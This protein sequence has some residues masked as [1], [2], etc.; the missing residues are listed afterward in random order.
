MRS[1]QTQARKITLA[2]VLLSG[3]TLQPVMTGQSY[4]IETPPDGACPRLE[5]RFVVNAQGT[6][7]AAVT[8]ASWQPVAALS[9]PFGADDSFRMTRSDRGPGAVAGRF[10]SQVSTIAI[11]GDAA[12]QACAGKTFNLRLWPFYARSPFT[13]GSR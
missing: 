11:Q 2:T 12:G 7:D 3:C 10:T 6:I 1:R 4:V 9:G 13:G 5:W 8:T